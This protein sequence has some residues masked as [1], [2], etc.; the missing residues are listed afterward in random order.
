M[1]GT[2]VKSLKKNDVS[3]LTGLANLVKQKYPGYTRKEVFELIK[4]VR[5]RNSGKLVGLK[6]KKF[7]EI[8]KK[9]VKED[10]AIDKIQEKRE[11]KKKRA[12]EATCPF[13]YKLFIEKFSRDRHVK[14]IHHKQE[15]REVKTATETA[16][17][18]TICK[19]SFYHLSNLKRHMRL[20]EENPPE[21]QCDICGEKFTR[22]DNLFKHRE[23]LHELFK[24]N[25]DAIDACSQQ[26]SLHCKMC[27]AQFQADIDAF[28]TRIAN[29]VCKK[30][31][32]FIVVNNR[33][34]IEC[35][36]CEK[37][38]VDV[39]SLRRH[40]HSNHGSGKKKLICEKCRKE[41]AYRSSL[42]KHMKEKH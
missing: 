35:D 17:E 4:K 22:E 11:K 33:G 10:V 41:F 29:E 23:R 31:E 12:L 14:K 42:V 30:K 20:H 9:I 8:V 7:F 25:F 18:C 19:K 16:S 27:G 26:T 1:E 13:C 39:K 37:T 15:H 6:M 36:L 24:I 38:Y 32:D 40:L 34:R 2:T 28:R 5:D 21:F 3:G